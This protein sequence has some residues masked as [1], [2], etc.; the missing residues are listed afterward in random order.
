MEKE[1][2]LRYAMLGFMSCTSNQSIA[3][4]PESSNILFIVVDTLRADYLAPAGAPYEIAPNLNTLAAE[5]VVLTRHYATSSWTRP[6]FATLLTG[7]Y[8]SE[9]GI[10][11]E[12]F[13]RLPEELDTLPE[14][15]SQ[16][17]FST[18][19]VNSN[20]N[21]DPYFG[22]D[23][24][25]AS[26][27]EA[28]ARFTWMGGQTET[29]KSLVGQPFIP[30]EGI[31]KSAL[32]QLKNRTEPWF[33]M[34]VYIDPHLPYAPL[35]IDEA[36][37]RGIPE[38]YHPEYA[39]EVHHADREIGA[40]LKVLEQQGVLA[41]TYVII[42]SD[43]GEGLWSHPGVPETFEHGTQL[44][45]SMNHVPFMIWHPQLKARKL[46]QITSSISVFPTVLDILGIAREHN[47]SRPS[48]RVLLSEGAQADLPP[49]AFSQTHWQR[50]NKR[51]VRSAEGRYIYSQDAFD[52][53]VQHRFEKSLPLRDQALLEGP[54]EEFYP[55]VSCWVSMLCWEQYREAWS[56]NQID[57]H[58][59]DLS[60]VLKDWH[61]QL[62]N[63]EP[64]QRDPEDGYSSFSWE[65]KKM[66]DVE[67]H[68]RKADAVVPPISESMKKQLEQLGYME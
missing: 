36:A 43:H 45:D 57:Q 26:F 11:E 12:K 58:D 66:V 3:D 31:T 20:P 38:H 34:L 24:G 25:F 4:L 39:A 55:E 67:F 64:L 62:H 15:L 22:F 5:S 10:Y 28:G 50:L 6:G 52:F 49:Y 60:A 63:R 56:Y 37:V 54:Y 2:L 65:N 47:P 14:I 13:D 27:Q 68:P 18:F 30:A 40:L 1:M 8:P 44:Y 16:N 35:P 19:A 17:G 23:Q 7:L 32:L 42:T 46:D 61:Q 59:S 53:Q 9:A 48:L 21:I 29:E 51:S 41:N 33:G